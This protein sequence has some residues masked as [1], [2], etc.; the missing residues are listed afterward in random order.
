MHSYGTA[1]VYCVTA[2]CVQRRGRRALVCL[3]AHGPAQPLAQSADEKVLCFSRGG[4]FESPN[5]FGTG[6]SS[7]TT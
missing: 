6:A 4:F 2:V 1:F 7:M 5:F 3:R